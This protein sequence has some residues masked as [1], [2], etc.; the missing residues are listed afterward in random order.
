MDRTAKQQELDA[1]NEEVMQIYKSMDSLDAHT[2]LDVLSNYWQQMNEK[3]DA[4]TPCVEC[5]KQYLMAELE[6]EAEGH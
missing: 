4:E 2:R 1:L 3:C 6:Y 5:R